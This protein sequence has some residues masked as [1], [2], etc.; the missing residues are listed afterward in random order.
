MVF[1]TS[2]LEKYATQ[3]SNGEHKGLADTTRD[4]GGSQSGFRPH[5]LLEAALAVCINM[6]VRMYA[7]SHTLPLEKVEVKVQLD[8]NQSP[9][10]ALF[11]YEI[12]LEGNLTPEQKEKLLHVAQSCPVR[13]TL[14]R[15]IR[16]E[17][18]Q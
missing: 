18:V 4:K 17:A 1:S 11:R 14:S 8:R 7:D 15:K 6:Y 2:Q 9:E 16:F 5:D 12:Q 13:R 10:E 3:F